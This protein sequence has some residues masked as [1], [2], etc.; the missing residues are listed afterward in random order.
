MARFAVGL[1]SLSPRFCSVLPQII[2]A[3][4]NTS[5]RLSSAI[6]QAKIVEA[7]VGRINLT[8]TGA[9]ARFV[10]SKSHLQQMK[11]HFE[12]NKRRYVHP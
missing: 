6:S 3:P 8:N 1:P 2:D 12:R 10:T 5:F 7:S 9:Q 4:H 11:K